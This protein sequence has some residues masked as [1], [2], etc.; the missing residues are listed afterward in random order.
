MSWNHRLHRRTVLKGLLAGGVV[1]LGLPVLERFCNDAGTAFADT[2]GDGFPKRFGLFFWGNGML[3]D[4]WVPATQG[5][6]Y[7]LSQQLQPLAKWQDR[8]TVVTGTRLKVPNTQP[9]GAGAAGVL[10]GHPLLHQG[11]NT[12]F[13]APS[14]DQIL[15]ERIGGETRF[16]S[17]EVGAAPGDGL[18]HNGPNSLNP[19]ESSPY[20]LF[21]RLFG[22]GFTLPGTTPKVDPSLGLRRSVLDAV[23]EELKSLRN[24]VGSA[25]R[26]RLDQHAEGVRQLE[27]R[28]A[29]LEE[30]PPKLD[31]CKVPPPP[32][33]D[34]PDVEGRPQLLQKN[35]ALCDLLAYALACDQVRVFS[36][37]FSYPVNNLLFPQAPT[38]HHELTHNEPGD[39]P[40]VHAITLH[41]L[42]AL[43]YQIQALASIPEGAGTLL[44]HC[45]VLGTSEVSLGKTHS[46]DEMPLILAGSA[47]GKLKTGLHVRTE[48]GTNTSRVLLSV[49][50]AVAGDVP[51]FGGAQGKADEGLSEVEA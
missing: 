29:K 18:S 42:T 49:C 19:P 35:Q 46:M 25:D 31:A 50:R 24:H 41:C 4:R 16:R 14:I 11:G 48:G 21:D 15:A 22:T 12:T 3:P 51:S 47:G 33:K 44:D 39:Q 17:L 1:T 6:G 36:N 38:G 30:A 27:K 28:L 43:A 37:F 23:H 34:F 45:V 13:A 7:A 5:K 9:H 8:F 10:S 2:T 32:Q 26:Q 20:A 40:E